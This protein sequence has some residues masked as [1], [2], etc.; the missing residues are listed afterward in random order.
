MPWICP[1]LGEDGDLS[2]PQF[3]P[4]EDTGSRIRGW[5]APQFREN[6]VCWGVATVP[7]RGIKTVRSIVSISSPEHGT[8]ELRKT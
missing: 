3:P 5:R 7:G 2:P 1:L 4:R 8:I 6:T